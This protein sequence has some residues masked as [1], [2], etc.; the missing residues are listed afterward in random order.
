MDI[1]SISF[2][3]FSK[4]PRVYG[5]SNLFYSE[6]TN[7]VKCFALADRDFRDPR[8]SAKIIDEAKKEHL[9]LHVWKRKEI[10]NYF[11]IPEILYQLVPKSYIL[12]Y[13][14]FL[15]LLN[16]LLDE[17]QDKV[18]EAFAS[19]YR[20]DSRELDN[21]QQ[22]EVSTCIQESRKFL[23]SNWT[24]LDNKI[25]LVGGKDF[26]SILA[27]YYQDNFKTHLTIKKIIENVTLNTLSSEIS[28]FLSQL[29]S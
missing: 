8:M 3:G 5:T 24:T 27:K 13:D 14:D 15:T 17:Q 6:T 23:K 12:S 20:M 7:Q 4:I 11:I 21:G 22:W 25:S 9:I 26:L 10:E 28:D 2:G 16:N 18:F 1:P 29:Q 19:Q